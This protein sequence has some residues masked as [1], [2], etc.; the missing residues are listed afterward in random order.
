MQQGEKLSPSVP[1]VLIYSE[2]E[3]GKA[4]LLE[5]FGCFLQFVEVF[6]K[7]VL[8]AFL[9]GSTH[10]SVI[11]ILL[12]VFMGLL[13]EHHRFSVECHSLSCLPSHFMA[14]W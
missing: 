2:R 9:R 6:S 5:V 12:R 4:P 1:S 8:Q 13:D 7:S 14:E 10:S 3:R 11:T